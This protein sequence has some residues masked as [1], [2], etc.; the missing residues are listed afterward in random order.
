MTGA[1]TWGRRLVGSHQVIQEPNRVCQSRQLLPPRIGLERPLD[2]LEQSVLQ[3]GQLSGASNQQHGANQRSS[4]IRRRLQNR[5][6]NYVRQTLR[7]LVAI[8]QTLT[9]ALTDPSRNS[10]NTPGLLLLQPD[11]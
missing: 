6:Q 4:K 1:S 8:K 9:R 2:F 5:F 3:V 10:Q 7:I 11:I